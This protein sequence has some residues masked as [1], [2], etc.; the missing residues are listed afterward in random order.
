[1]YHFQN[2]S[3]E[4]NILINWHNYS[5]YYSVTLYIPLSACLTHSHTPSITHHTLSHHI[6]LSLPSSV[7]PC[8]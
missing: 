5:E 7:T 2:I 4:N 6:D 3:V 1:M 8:P